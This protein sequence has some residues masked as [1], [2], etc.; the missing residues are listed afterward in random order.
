MENEKG[1]GKSGIYEE[2]FYY[3]ELFRRFLDRQMLY[4]MHHSRFGDRNSYS[5]TDMDAIFMHM[6]DDH[7]RNVQLKPGNILEL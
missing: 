4:D 5:K 1:A 6:K 7:M 2:F 3:H